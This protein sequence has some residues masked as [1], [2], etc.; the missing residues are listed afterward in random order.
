MAA[1]RRDSIDVLRGLALVAMVLCHYPIFLSSGAGQDAMLFFLSNHL[2]GGDFGASWFVFLVG[3]CQALSSMKA[4]APGSGST[5]RTIVRGAAIFVIGLLF[6]YFLQGYEELWDWDILTFIGA[7]TI[8]LIPV[9]RMPNWSVLLA[10]AAIFFMTPWLRSFVDLAPLYGGGFESVEWFSNHFPNL[11]FDPRQ[12]YQGAH[13]FLGNVLGFVLIGQFP[14]FPWL[15]YPL[16][17]FVVGRKMVQN[18]LASDAPFILLLGLSFT[19]LGLFA[20]TAGSQRAVISVPNDY[21]TPLSFYPLSF[22]MCWFLLGVV[23]MLFIGL[24]RRYDATPQ[25]TEKVS[26]F[27]AYT[28]LMSKY[29]LTVYISHFALFLIPFRIVKFATGTDLHKNLVSTPT[30]FAMGIALLLLYTPVLRR[31]DAA[32]GKFSCEWLLAKILSHAQTKAS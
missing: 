19:F 30:A 22:S 13:S 23:L 27:L 31:W 11:L 28:R 20:A 15:A 2:L 7:T 1:Q 16:V 8:L 5:R 12:D 24:W 26:V 3:L 14:L 10:C 6:L 4:D 29:S 25:D 32:G 9:R 18:Q 17:G 21:I